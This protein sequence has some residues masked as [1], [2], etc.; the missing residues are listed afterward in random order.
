MFDQK[1]FQIRLLRLRL[2]LSARAEPGEL[3]T[4]ANKQFVLD[5]KRLLKA[6]K[7]AH[8]P[9]AS[10]LAKSE[11]KLAV[12]K[13]HENL[14]RFENCVKEADEKSSVNSP[15][16]HTRSVESNIDQG[17]DS[18]Y[19]KQTQDPRDNGNAEPLVKS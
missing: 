14:T 6:E 5:R 8:L 9:N 15:N 16:Q 18:E 10:P 3:A 17:V 11:L 12:Q 4:R 7:E 2:R 1:A 13:I 19:P